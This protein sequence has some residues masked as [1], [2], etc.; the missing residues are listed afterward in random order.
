MFLLATQPGQVMAILLRVLHTHYPG[1]PIR[2][3]HTG[4]VAYLRLQVERGV[5]STHLRLST[6]MKVL[7]QVT[8]GSETSFSK[9][10]VLLKH[11]LKCY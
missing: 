5:C 3:L 11:V 7:K 9:L 2:L 8:T 6:S 4:L 1:K 10:N